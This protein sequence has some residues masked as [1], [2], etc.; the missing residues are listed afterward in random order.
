MAYHPRRCAITRLMAAV[1]RST[2]GAVL[3]ALLATATAAAPPA[4]RDEPIVIGATPTAILIW[5]A[6]DLGLFEQEGVSVQVREYQSGTLTLPALIAEEV[7]LSTNSEFSFV[8]NSF[9][10]PELR[11]L[12]TLSASRTTLI[13]GRRDRGVLTVMD[14]RG[15]R[16]GVT[17]KSTGLYVLGVYLAMH[18][19]RLD[20]VELVDLN[21]TEIVEAIDRG[22]VDAAITW[23]PFVYQARNRLGGRIAVLPDQDSQFFHFLLSGRSEWIDTHRTELLKVMQAL[24]RAE[25]YALHRPERAKQL[26]AR[27]FSL[28]EDFID[29]LWPK[30]NLRIGMQ[31]GLIG[32]MEEE[33]AWRIRSGLVEA[34]TPPDFLSMFA[35]EFLQATKPSSVRLIP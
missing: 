5:L 20:D 18:G 2:G 15:R 4:A 13:F 23:E 21:P 35:S 3:A 14:L 17:R 24:H 7:D 33:A 12:T 9:A 25:D 29:Y 34:D 22:T 19:I 8:S 32:L 1:G 26:F 27:R 31:Q 6:N 16:I 11:V 28:S 30:H 10:H